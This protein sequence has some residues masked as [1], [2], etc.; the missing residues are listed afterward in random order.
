M[1]IRPDLT[2][3]VME[4]IRQAEPPQLLV[5]GD[6]PWVSTFRREHCKRVM[7][8]ATYLDTASAVHTCFSE[9]S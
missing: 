9:K 2:T 3:Q 4:Q 5:G 6:C 8:T 7:G 1:V